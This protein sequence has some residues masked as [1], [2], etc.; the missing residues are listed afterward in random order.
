M[1]QFEHLLIAGLHVNI[2]TQTPLTASDRPVVVLFLLHGRHGSALQIRQHVDVI[3]ERSQGLQDA[4][5]LL[6]VTFVPP[7]FT[8]L[9]AVY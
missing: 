5:E 7:Y 9:N 1:T 4:C 2:F 8:Y 3:L 6:V